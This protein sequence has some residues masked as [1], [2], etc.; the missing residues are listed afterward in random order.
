ME[1]FAASAFSGRARLRRRALQHVLSVRAT[2]RACQSAAAHG[3]QEVIEP[4]AKQCGVRWLSLRFP[5]A[6]SHPHLQCDGFAEWPCGALAA[7]VA[8]L[9]SVVR[10]QLHMAT[11]SAHAD[12]IP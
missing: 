1:N 10:L 4:Q 7:R 11:L 9:S 12:A 3:R 5:P 8:V 6:S 2:G